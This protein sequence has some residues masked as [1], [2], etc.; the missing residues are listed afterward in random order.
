MAKEDRWV[1]MHTYVSPEDY[2]WLRRRAF[3]ERKSI[4]RVV[5]DLII[6][7]RRRAEESNRE[8]GQ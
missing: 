2:E 3:E 1:D 4:A 7:A 8:R 6:E 5:R